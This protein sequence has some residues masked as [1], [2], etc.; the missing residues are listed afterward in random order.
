MAGTSGDTDLE[1]LRRRA[2][3]ALR[4]PRSRR[5]VETLL[6]R[7][8]SIAPTDSES[9]AFAHR[10]LAELLIEE[11]PWRAALHLRHVAQLANDD[12]VVHALMGLC[13]A[14]L[15]NFHSAVAAYRRALSIAPRNPWYH[16]NLGHLLDVALGDPRGAVEHLRSAHR[17]EPLEH[18]ITA[19]LA[20]CLARVGEIEEARVLADEAVR[21]APRNKDHRALLAWVERGAPGERGPRVGGRA[22]RERSASTTGGGRS[23]RRKTAADSGAKGAGRASGAA[24]RSAPRANGLR[25]EGTTDVL[26]A[27]ERGMREA[28][29]SAGQVERARALW[30]DFRD[31]RS[32]R[33]IKPEV[34]A[35]AVEYAIALV[36]GLHGVTQA[37]IAKRYGIGGSTLRNRYAEIREALSL[38]PGDPRY[39]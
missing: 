13:Q 1:R 22:K 15:G 36:H 17:M 28:G 8:L 23:R 35:A 9:A 31:G 25:A 37:S 26:R 16:H 32:V 30:A 5:E 18:E 11:H 12:D 21:A 38:Q 27:L 2:E 6:E 33:I 24:D 19:S 7:I 3:A 29:F 39:A 34:Y 10:H 20:H 14:L 4:R